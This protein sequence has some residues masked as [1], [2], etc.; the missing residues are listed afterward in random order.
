[1][2]YLV[3]SLQCSVRVQDNLSVT[4]WKTFGRKGLGSGFDLG[5]GLVLFSEL[6]KTVWIAIQSLSPPE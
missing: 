2:V 5:A 4:V 3:I 6:R 1:M